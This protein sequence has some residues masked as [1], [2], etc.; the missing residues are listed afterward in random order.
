MLFTAAIVYSDDMSVADFIAQV[1]GT[2]QDSEDMNILVIKLSGSFITAIELLNC[3]SVIGQANEILVPSKPDENSMR[4]AKDITQMIYQIA[5]S[6]VR[7]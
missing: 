7:R 6:A 5:M 2:R 1:G 4:F 3:A